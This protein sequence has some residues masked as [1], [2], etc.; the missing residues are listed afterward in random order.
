MKGRTRERLAKRVRLFRLARGWSQE[1]LADVCGLHRSYIGSVERA[2]RN[3]S[4]DNVEK[5]AQALGIPIRDLIDPK[6]PT[7]LSLDANQV[8]L[9]PR[10]R[11]K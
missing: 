10:K 2:E 11:G 3:I 7:I 1:V 4:I 6:E 9:N 8:P 5:I